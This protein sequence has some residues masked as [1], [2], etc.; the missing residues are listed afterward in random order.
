MALNWGSEIITENCAFS[1]RRS[2]LEFERYTVKSVRSIQ[3]FVKDQYR[4]VNYS[5]SR[6]DLDGM[7]DRMKQCAQKMELTGIGVRIESGKLKIIPVFYQNTKEGK[8]RFWP[9]TEHQ[10]KLLERMI[11][12]GELFPVDYY[13]TKK[14]KLT[15]S[16]LRKILERYN[17]IRFVTKR[18]E[19]DP[20]KDRD[21]WAVCGK[22]EEYKGIY[23]YEEMKKERMLI[24]VFARTENDPKWRFCIGRVLM[25]SLDG[26]NYVL[27]KVKKDYVREILQHELFS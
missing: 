25:T 18:F 12:E 4:N 5:S 23:Y 3:G 7:S 6:W 10:R 14:K 27:V 8:R 19:H 22:W 15:D 9:W 17:K 1:L 20:L 16:L 21:E 24:F 13:I 2:I 26:D 11:G